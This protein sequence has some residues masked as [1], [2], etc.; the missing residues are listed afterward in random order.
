MD[1]KIAVIGIGAMFVVGLFATM[2]FAFAQETE[3][4]PA[5]GFVDED[6]DDVCDNFVD[7][8]GD[9][10]CDNKGQREGFADADG[11][12]ECDYAGDCPMHQDKERSMQKY[13]KRMGG[14]HGSEGCPKMK[15]GFKEGCH[16]VATE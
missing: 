10:V 4:A 6:S 1:R 3:N 7:G 16:R 15:D 5:T 9:G 14:C 11:D 12:G 2:G 13:H 8:D